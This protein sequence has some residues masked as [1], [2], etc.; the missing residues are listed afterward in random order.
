MITVSQITTDI[1]MQDDV[2]FA[3]AQKGWLNLSSYARAIQPQIQ[4]ALLKDIQL[5]S[6][7]TALSRVVATI[8][9]A[10]K[11]PAD[12]VQGFTVHTGLE[13]L[14]YERS[15]Q[16]SSKIREIYNKTQ[17]QGKAFLTITQGLNE[18]TII[19]ESQ[20]AQHFRDQL[21][22][23]PIVYDKKDLVGVTVKL[24]TGY[25]ETPNLIYASNRRLAYKQ[26]NIVEIVSTATELTY[27]IHKKD[28]STALEQLQKDI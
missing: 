6:I 19:A 22:A 17:S 18:I 13:G 8:P 24:K 7:I 3:A 9:S 21:Q 16:A 20:T 1:L 27:L 12:F 14:T 2:A 23:T 11:V 26:V 28:L 5:N 25:L 4:T 10:S 15:E